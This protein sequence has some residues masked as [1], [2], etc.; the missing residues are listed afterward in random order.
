[1]AKYLE[2]LD[3]NWGSFHQQRISTCNQ[4]SFQSC[5]LRNA[6]QTEL[7][8]AWDSKVAPPWVGQ[9]YDPW[10]QQNLS[11]LIICSTS[12]TR[13]AAQKATVIAQQFS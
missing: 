3:E 2:I 1:M 10:L 7:S 12:L 9:E 8:A 11:N 13:K 4:A 6:E 5:R